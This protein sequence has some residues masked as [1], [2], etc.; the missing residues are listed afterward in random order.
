MSARMLYVIMD[1]L[2]DRPIPELGGRTPL[3]AAHT[4]CF[5]GL[6]AS[7]LTG[8][9][10][11][12]APGV[13]VG[14]DVGH[15]CLFGYDPEQIYAGRGPLEAV[16]AGLVLG[17]DEVAWRGNFA[18]IDDADQLL[19]KRAG[20]ICAGTA[21]LAHALS[22]LDL[23]D[24]VAVRVKE[25]TEHRAAVVFTGPRLS[26]QVSSAYPGPGDHLPLPFPSVRPLDDSSD[27]AFTAAKVNLFIRRAKDI[28]AAH[29]VNLARTAAGRPPANALLLRSPGRM[30]SMPSF[31]SRFGIRA[32]LVGGQE[33]VLALAHMAGMTV[34][35]SPAMT[36]G[37]KTDLAAKALA[38]QKLLRE[39]EL[40]FVHVK[41]PDLAG[42]DNAPERKMRIIESVDAMLS[43]ILQTWPDPLFVAVGA[44]HS[45]PCAFMEHSGDPV[46]VLLSGP[47][48]RIDS[49]RTF[50]ESAAMQGGLG[51]LT[52]RDF[53]HEVLNAAYLVP[54]QGA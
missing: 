14:T 22:G 42:H 1:G 4:P 5:D 8:L 21:E 47:G 34:V 16:G 18:T 35:T 31:S 48:L 30:P 25:A 40:V 17:D 7:G 45:T 23:G 11:L 13:P 50:G 53:L 3:E 19:D 39:H 10:H 51:H 43:N 41:G 38:A 12:L 6:A 28:L 33:T 15:I 46:P 20:R 49:T 44:D 54:K 24:G 9:M 26:T 32:G 2:G 36:G 52:G 27:A 37:L 29:P